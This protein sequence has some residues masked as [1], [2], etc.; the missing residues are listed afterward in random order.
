[1]RIVY[2]YDS[3]G[4]FVEPVEIA[5]TASIPK[6]C[7]DKPL[8]QPN[9]KPVFKNGAWVETGTPPAHPPAVPSPVE[10]LQRQTAQL[11]ADLA[12]FM[13]YVFGGA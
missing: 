7:T 12:A 11:N 1:M 6:N 8:P 4:N 2:K 10:E 13:D 3:L 9:Y 5:D